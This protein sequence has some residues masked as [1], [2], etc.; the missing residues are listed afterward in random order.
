MQKVFIT[1]ALGRDAEFKKTKNG[2][3]VLSFPVGVSQGYG[4][5]KQTNWFRCSLWGKRAQSLH[6]Y[7]TKGTK[8]AVEGSLVIGEYEGKAQYNVTVDQDALELMSRNDAPARQP[9]AHDKAKQNGYQRDD[10]LDDE[11]PF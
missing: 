4:D 3:E 10:Y 6:T 11:A 8:V 7:L 2:D 5:N 9:T 1:G